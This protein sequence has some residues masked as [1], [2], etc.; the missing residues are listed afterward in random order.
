MNKQLMLDIQL[1]EPRLRSLEKSLIPESRLEGKVILHGKQKKCYV[2]E[3][4]N[5]NYDDNY[6]GKTSTDWNSNCHIPIIGN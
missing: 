6:K 5:K 4:F 1:Y 3:L 2:P